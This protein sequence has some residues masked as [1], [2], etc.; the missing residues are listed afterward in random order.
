MQNITK[1]L[2]KWAALVAIILAIP[3]VL[4]VRDGGV[5]GVGW[6]WTFFDFVFMGVLLFGSALTYELVARKMSNGTYRA[7]VGLAVVTS[8]ILVWI[9]AAVGIIGDDDGFNLMYFGVLAVGFSGALIVRFQAHGMARTMFVV[10]VAQALVPVIALII[11]RPDT[12]GPPGVFGVFVLNTFFVMMF[13]GSAILFRRV[14][15]TEPK[16]S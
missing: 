15:V 8:V 12:W 7:A 13:V 3:L 5:E 2:M 9:N 14:S 11:S 4:T 16:S 6:N 10:A 1:R